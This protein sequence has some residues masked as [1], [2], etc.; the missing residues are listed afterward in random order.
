MHEIHKL[1]TAR[2]TPVRIRHL[3]LKRRDMTK[4]FVI[5]TVLFALALGAAFWFRLWYMVPGC[6]IGV[7]ASLLVGIT[8]SRE[9]R[10][11]AGRG[12]PIE[13]NMEF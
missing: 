9:R 11:Y 3:L 12:V 7:L 1:A 10:Y 2:S 6:S 4:K 8:D 5:L 13:D